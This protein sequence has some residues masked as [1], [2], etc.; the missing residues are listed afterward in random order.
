MNF[1]DW[2]SFR[3]FGGN[4]LDTTSPCKDLNGNGIPDCLENTSTMD[5]YDLNGN[6]ICDFWEMDNDSWTASSWDD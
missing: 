5:C 1:W 6:G 2:F 4:D 3:W